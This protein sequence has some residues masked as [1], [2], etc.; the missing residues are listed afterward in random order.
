MRGTHT[1]HLKR[2]ENWDIIIAIELKEHFNDGI[3]SNHNEHQE[4][5]QAILIR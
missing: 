1:K 5:M 3:C 2:N 4:E